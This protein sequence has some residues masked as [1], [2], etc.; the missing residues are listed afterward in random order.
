MLAKAEHGADSGFVGGAI[1]DSDMRHTHTER[2]GHSRSGGAPG[3][4]NIFKA[5]LYMLK[6]IQLMTVTSYLTH[7][8]FGPNRM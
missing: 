4:A 2:D 6:D 7:T 5:R 3:C 1:C 8:L